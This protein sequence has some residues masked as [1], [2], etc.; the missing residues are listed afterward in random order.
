MNNDEP[1]QAAEKV[2]TSRKE[3]NHYI[4]RMSTQCSEG[5]RSLQCRR[6]HINVAVISVY[7]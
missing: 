2:V 4:T 3:G 1:L 5:G 7:R 6:Q